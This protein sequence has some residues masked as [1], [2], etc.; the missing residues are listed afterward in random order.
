LSI[1]VGMA[2]V[3]ITLPIFTMKH[4]A[5]ALHAVVV[6]PYLVHLS[7]VTSQCSAEMAKHRITQ[8]VLRDRLLGVSSFPVPKILTKFKLEH[9]QQGCL[10]RTG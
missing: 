8:T 10:M 3:R 7:V 1:N 5:S 9:P 4:C 2:S 6:C